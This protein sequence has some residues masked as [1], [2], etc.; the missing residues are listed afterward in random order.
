MSRRSVH[1]IVPV[2]PVSL[3]VTVTLPPTV[4]PS[5]GLVIDAVI[6]VSRRV[7]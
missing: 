3:I 1:V 2:P 6:V 7:I 5:V 4:V